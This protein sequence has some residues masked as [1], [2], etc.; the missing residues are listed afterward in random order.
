MSVQKDHALITS[1]PYSVV[2]HPSYIGSVAIAVGTG[3]LQFAAGSWFRECIGLG[4]WGS[5]V[6]TGVWGGWWVFLISMLLSRVPAED[7]I[8]R[9]EFGAEWDAWARRTPY[10]LIPYIY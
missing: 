8:M 6:F 5:R 7:E 1:G 10:R 9:K 3:L 2:R 4:S